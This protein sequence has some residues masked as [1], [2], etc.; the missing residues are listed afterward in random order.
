MKTSVLLIDDHTLFSEGLSAL[1]IETNRFETIKHL[2]D[3]ENALTH[4]QKHPPDLVLLDYYFPSGNGLD[5]GKSIL[6]ILPN[7][8]LILLTMVTDYYIVNQAKKIGFAGYLP[9][10]TS[11]IELL[12]AITA[13]LNNEI[14]FNI[15][16]FDILDPQNKKNNPL[17][18][19]E[20][21]IAKLVAQGYSTAKIAN[22][23]FISELTVSTHR[24]NI[25][26]K[27]NLENSVQLGNYVH[28]FN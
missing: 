15:S 17:S 9:K 5:I 13:I 3:L 26:R 19:R 11:L 22:A 21:Q 7:A 10:N 12:D 20:K 25:L 8:K 18:N 4:C 27:L 14:W 6:K 23:L 2:P 28:L 16:T 24:K 1:L